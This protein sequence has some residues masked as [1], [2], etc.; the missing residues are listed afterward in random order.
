[1]P[2][3][4]FG[5]IHDI[6][7]VCGTCGGDHADGQHGASVKETGHDISAEAHEMGTFLAGLT[8]DRTAI[9][10][11]MGDSLTINSEYGFTRNIV[12]AREDV[13]RALL[14]NPNFINV[15]HEKGEIRADLVTPLGPIKKII[16]SI[17]KDT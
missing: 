15:S 17:R 8:G 10:N 4:R 6:K 13:F 16:V 3:Q 7:Y 12:R 11:R 9:V 5:K 2:E 1:M 14:D